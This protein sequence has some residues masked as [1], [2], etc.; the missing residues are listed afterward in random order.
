MTRAW[1]P[2]LTLALVLAS[3]LGHIGPARAGAPCSIANFS[4]ASHIGPARAGAPLSLLQAEQRVARFFPL[5]TPRAGTTVV[6]TNRPT[7]S[8]SILYANGAAALVDQM[9]GEILNITTTATVSLH[10]VTLTEGAALAVATSLIKA[11][12]SPRASLVQLDPVQTPQTVQDAVQVSFTRVVNG[13]LYPANGFRVSVN[14][15]RSIRSYQVSWSDQ[16][17]FAPPYHLVG[18]ARAIQA[19]KTAL[20]RQATAYLFYYLLLSSHSPQLLYLVKTPYTDLPIYATTGQPVDPSNEQTAKAAV[21]AATAPASST[22]GGLVGQ[23]PLLAAFVAG[24]AAM[25]AGRVRQVHPLPRDSSGPKRAGAAP[26]SRL[27]RG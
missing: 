10:R 15:D 3:S 12:D 20:T 22:L 2:G 21:A 1:L 14:Q 13:I 26:A 8:W 5:G 6:P 11:V 9:T 25:V 24:A 16:T 19:A 18:T 4:R 27:R 7:P 17:R 23:W